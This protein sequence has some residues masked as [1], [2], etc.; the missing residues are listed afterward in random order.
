MLEATKEIKTITVDV[1]NLLTVAQAIK[2]KQS[3]IT[4]VTDYAQKT[5]YVK[6]N[7]IVYTI[8]GF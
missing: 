6:G 7:G 3:R 8:Q 2:K 5:I 4:L 1:Q